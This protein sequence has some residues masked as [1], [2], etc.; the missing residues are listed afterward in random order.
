MLKR[1]S[2]LALALLTALACLCSCAPQ[3]ALY[4]PINDSAYL[5]VSASPSPVDRFS[6]F[7]DLEIASEYALVYDV[8]AQK[9]LFTKGGVDERVYPA[10]LTKLYTSYVALKY[11][12]ADEMVT[13]GAEELSMVKEISLDTSE[14]SRLEALADA[15]GVVSKGIWEPKLPM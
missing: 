13:V 8:N 7:Y 14:I 15:S 6:R 2:A 4:S 1:I 12:G 10:S 3:K 11:I 5:A 9:I